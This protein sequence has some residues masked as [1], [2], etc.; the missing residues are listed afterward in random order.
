MTGKTVAAF[1]FLCA[2]P[3]AAEAQSYR[4]IGAD[5]KR[6]YGSAIPQECFRRPVEQLNAQ[7]LVVKRIDPAA[8]E[9]ERRAKE[10]ADAK[11]REDET[12]QREASR[13]NQ[14][15]LAT[16]TSEKDIEEARTRALADNGRATRELQER[17]EAIRK[18]QA[19]YEKEAAL[20]KGKPELPIKLRDDM[21][22]AENE[23][24]AQ[25]DL[26]ENKQRE[27]GAIN[28]RYDEDKKRYGAITSRR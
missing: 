14:A 21:R 9:K 5:G 10:A 24:K 8:A 23:L 18:R 13:R 20:H 25:Q 3:L 11:K 22:I 4:C 15:L 28:A 2:L 26:L 17:I 16:Y 6:Y 7:G 19:G 1:A 27:A 12:V